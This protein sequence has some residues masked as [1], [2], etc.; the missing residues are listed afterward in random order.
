[1]NHDLTY[2]NEGRHHMKRITVNNEERAVPSGAVGR[3][4]KD[5]GKGSL[6]GRRAGMDPSTLLLLDQS[7]KTGEAEHTGRCSSRNV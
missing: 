6:D 7:W 4:E 5:P 2:G 1:M 3:R